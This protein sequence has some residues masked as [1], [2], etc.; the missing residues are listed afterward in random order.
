[1]SKPNAYKRPA[2]SRLIREAYSFFGHCISEM[3][4]DLDTMI[5]GTVEY[6]RDLAQI[7]TRLGRGC[8]DL[9]TAHA[10]EAIGFDLM[11]KAKELEDALR[12][13]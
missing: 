11:A 13:N 10:L 3:A 4:K 9:A 5:T 7:C 12:P 6:L 8:P 1:M 2:D